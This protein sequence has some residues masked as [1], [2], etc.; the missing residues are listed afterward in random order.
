MRILTIDIETS[1]NDAYVWHLFGDFVGIDKLNT[2]TR[3]LCYAAKF[4]LCCT[5]CSPTQTQ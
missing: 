1:P 4:C 3:M 5:N 2:P